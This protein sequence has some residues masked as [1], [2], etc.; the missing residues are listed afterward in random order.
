MKLYEFMLHSK[1][2]EAHL[3]VS[4][5]FQE[6]GY[7]HWFTKTRTPVSRY[8]QTVT[9]HD[10]VHELIVGIMDED[11]AMQFRLTF[12]AVMLDEPYIGLDFK[13]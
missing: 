12:D 4:K 2:S 7:D 1:G 8:I 13:K 9:R 10:F 11:V 3:A 5:W 6:Q